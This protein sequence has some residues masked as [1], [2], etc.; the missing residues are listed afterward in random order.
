MAPQVSSMLPQGATSLSSGTD[1][2]RV[3]VS[4][5]SF[6]SERAPTYNIEV[7]NQHTYF[8]DG[9]LVHNKEECRICELQ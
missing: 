6:E 1:I 2:H 9:V 8:A 4:S 3:V 7:A 5:L